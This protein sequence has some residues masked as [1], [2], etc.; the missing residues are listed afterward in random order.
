MPS[1][2]AS[3][4]TPKGPTARGGGGRGIL[5]L[6]L[7][8]YAAGVSTALL[9]KGPSTST[10]SG[11]SATAADS[12]ER[13]NEMSRQVRGWA[14]EDLEKALKEVKDQFE[15]RVKQVEEVR[16]SLKAVVDAQ[17]KRT[18]EVARTASTRVDSLEEK[19]EDLVNGQTAINN[20][21]DGLHLAVKDLQ[22]RPVSSGPVAVR[23]PDPKPVDPKPVEPEPV[24]PTPEQIA[25]N[26]EKVRA[27]IAEL[28]STDITKVFPAAA[29]LGGSGDL[30]AVEPLVK[31]LKEFKDPLGRTAAAAALGSLHACDSV[32]TLLAAFM[33]KDP[34]VFLA[35]G[36]S[37]G[38]IAGVDT[39]LAG[40]SSRKDRTKARDDWTKWWKEHEPEVRKKWN[41]EGKAPPEAP[42]VVPEPGMDAPPK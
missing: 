15:R 26:K 39:L 32:P 31:V 5:T 10:G 38:R 1:P 21:I 25:A 12:D 27:A 20:K 18:D 28:A 11:G 30:E 3:K 6:L 40:D 13:L 36:G 33:D 41:Q 23:P 24:G 2:R 29:F 22:A 42:P 35:A 19:L 17:A 14:K 7:A 34:G 4:E 16:D 8:L 37:F 9:F